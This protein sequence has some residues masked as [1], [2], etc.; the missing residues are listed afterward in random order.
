MQ[1]YILK[2]GTRAEKGYKVR[3]EDL[4]PAILY[5]SGNAPVKLSLP[6]ADV[7]QFLRWGTANMLIDL[8]AGDE[9]YT[10]ML[11]ELQ[12]HRIRDEVLHMDFYVV[13]LTQKLNTLVPI[14][15]IGESLGV[16]EEGGILQQQT[17]ELE[18]RC[19]PTEIP[20]GFDLDI[21]ELSI[22]DSRTVADLSIE[23]DIEILTPSTEVIVSVLAPRLETEEEEEA[24]G[25]DEEQ[26]EPAEAETEV[27]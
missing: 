27:E 12:R 18:V 13:D 3:R 9:N 24:E 25:V 6:K 10:V 21:N 4:V 1:R 8:T 7:N 5:G 19:L 17:R 20:Q 23:G 22:G 15:L 2:A 11:K 14:H 26:A 16:K